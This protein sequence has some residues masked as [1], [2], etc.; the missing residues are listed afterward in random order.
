M[1]AV[2]Q[3][4]T[5]EISMM[6]QTV[7]MTALRGPDGVPKYN[8]PKLL[9]RWF[10]RCVLKS[11]MDGR[12]LDTPYEINGGSFTGPSV[13]QPTVADYTP[14]WW[15]GA[16]EVHVNEYVAALDAIPH[17]FQ[18]HFLHAVEILGYKHPEVVTRS[19]WYTLY[20][21]LVNDLHLQPETEEQL[22]FRLGDSRE[23][24]LKTVDQAVVS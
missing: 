20:L 8:P 21:R 17:H 6:Q 19:F 14:D 11:A 23:Q 18:M 13:P 15:V 3:D 7:L 16:M 22:D 9:L 24:W 2:M 12:V 1:P 10:R 5:H 4:W